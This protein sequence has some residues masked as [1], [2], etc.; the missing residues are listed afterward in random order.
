M[1]NFQKES[2][3]GGG[4]FVALAVF[5]AALGAGA[6]LLL[7]P[8]EGA[9]T[10]KRVGRGLK[11]LGGEAAETIAEVSDRPDGISRSSAW[12]AFWWVQA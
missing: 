9:R 7:A 2:R 6:A 8:E 11:S 1:P 10:R 12:P 4:G 5:A 3:E